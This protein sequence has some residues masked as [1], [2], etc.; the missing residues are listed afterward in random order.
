MVTKTII[1]TSSFK[2]RKFHSKKKR[3]VGVISGTTN[4]GRT[5]LSKTLRNYMRIGGN[6]RS[7]QMVPRVVA[8]VSSID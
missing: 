6:S 2:K 3:S 4:I 7:L 1:K 8:N 5:Y